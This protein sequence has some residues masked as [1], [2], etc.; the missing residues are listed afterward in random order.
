MKELK[1]FVKNT[2]FYEQVKRV[3]NLAIYKQR[4]EEGRG[5]LAYEVIYIRR[6]AETKLFDNVMPAAEYGPS[7]EEFSRF[8]WSYPS[9]ELAQKKLDFLI[10]TRHFEENDKRNEKIE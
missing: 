4:L 8:G 10:E 1:N 7:N 3:G 5:C 6:R 2:F 9:L